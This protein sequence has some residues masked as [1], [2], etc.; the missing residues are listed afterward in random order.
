MKSA[1]FTLCSEHRLNVLTTP[2]K[3]SLAFNPQELKAKNQQFPNPK[4][5]IAIWDCADVEYEPYRSLH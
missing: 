3:I 2:C 1:S 4:E 5:Y